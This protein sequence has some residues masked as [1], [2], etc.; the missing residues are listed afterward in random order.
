MWYMLVVVYHFQDEVLKVARVLLLGTS[1]D[2]GVFENIF[3]ARPVDHHPPNVNLNL[4]SPPLLPVPTRTDF[5]L[6]FRFTDVWKE[7]LLQLE[8]LLYSS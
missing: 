1:T 4:G 3:L 5:S 7:K 8:V 2:P 6:K